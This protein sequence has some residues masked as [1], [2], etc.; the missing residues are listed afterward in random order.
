MGDMC[1]D[2]CIMGYVTTHECTVI[3][4]HAELECTELLVKGEIRDNEVA[5]ALPHGWR[6]PRHVTCI[7]HCCLRQHCYIVVTIG[8]VK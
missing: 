8:T 1:D 7:R 3:G 4:P 2:R 6:I 5:V